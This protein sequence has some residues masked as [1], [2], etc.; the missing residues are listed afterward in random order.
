[1]LELAGQVECLIHGDQKLV[2]VTIGILFSVIAS[3]RLQAAQMFLFF[4]ILGM[5]L[6]MNIRIPLLLTIVF[7]A[8]ILRA[9][10]SSSSKNS[11][12]LSL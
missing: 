3:T 9:D 7:T 2:R 5:V 8:P 10:S 12:T 4:F 6:F 1:M 11:I